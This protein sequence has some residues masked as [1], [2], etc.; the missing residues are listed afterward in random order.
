MRI[1][2]TKKESQ[3]VDEGIREFS[4]NVFALLPP[5]NSLPF[6]QGKTI[7]CWERRCVFIQF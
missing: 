7:R 3:T 4:D 2:Q 6:H 1:F 5:A